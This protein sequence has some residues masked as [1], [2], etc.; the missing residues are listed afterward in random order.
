MRRRPFERGVGGVGVTAGV[1]DARQLQHRLRVLELVAVATQDLEGLVEE[2]LGL[3]KPPTARGGAGQGD[4]GDPVEWVVAHALCLRD[5]HRVA[6]VR[7][8]LLVVAVLGGQ[9]RQ[10]R[11]GVDHHERLPVGRRPLAGDVGQ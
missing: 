5:V 1:A 7:Q 3:G 2:L 10:Q 4:G 8:R 11:E 6:G 9:Q